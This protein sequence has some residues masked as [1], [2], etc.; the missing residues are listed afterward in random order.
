[1]LHFIPAYFSAPKERMRFGAFL[2]PVPPR[3]FSS[4]LLGVPGLVTPRQLCSFRTGVLGEVILA[5]GCSHLK[6]WK[7]LSCWAR[8]LVGREWGN[9]E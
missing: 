1:M 4:L 6:Y 9:R 2:L 7:R 5:G 3:G 8:L